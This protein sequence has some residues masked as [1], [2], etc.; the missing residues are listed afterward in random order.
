MSLISLDDYLSLKGLSFCRY[1]DDL[2]IFCDSYELAQASIYEV[3]DFLDKSQKLGLNKQKTLI[4]NAADFKAK[5]SLM[6]VDNPIN[7]EEE[8]LLK[9]IQGHAG[10]YTKV[11]FD[12]LSADDLKF[13]QS[14]NIV[15][16]LQAYLQENTPNYVRLRWLLRRLSQTGVPS[17]IEF[18]VQNLQSLLPAIG[19][20]AAYINSAK[21]AYQGD[22]AGLGDALVT[23]LKLTVVTKNEYL[24]MV[25]LSLFSRIYPLNHFDKL[26]Q[27]FDTYSDLGRREILLAARGTNQ[28]TPWLQ[29]LKGSLG[30]MDPWQR[31]AYLFA[32]IQLPKDERKH[33]LSSIKGYLD[34]LERAIGD[35]VKN[36]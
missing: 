6:L 9:I 19:D 10:P 17:S 11:A 7:K 16:I 12:Q 8:Q 14:A 3:A 15:G 4:L 27:S 2:H 33:W 35:T 5:A 20:V 13:I 1:V 22:W 21:D 24:Q 30:K 29:T 31:R 26:V 18:V 25:L 23:A 34:P 32:S 28:A 36:A